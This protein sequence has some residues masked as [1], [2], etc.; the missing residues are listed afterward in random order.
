MVG[1]IVARL[2]GIAF[3]FEGLKSVGRAAGVAGQFPIEFRQGMAARA[4]ILHD[5]GA[6]APANWEYPFGTPDVHVALAIYAKAIKTCNRSWSSR[7]RLISDLPQISV[8]YRMPFG[9]LPEGR[10]PFGYKDG[11]HNPH[12]EGS[13]RP[14]AGRRRRSRP[15]SSSWAIPTSPAISLTCRFRASCAT[16]ALSWHFANSTWTLPRFADTSES[17]PHHRRKRN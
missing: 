14:A 6:N 1:A 7:A 2:V 15:A 3:T 4:A 9:E 11:L 10:N 13:G 12:V 17:R 16:T 8:V 5:F